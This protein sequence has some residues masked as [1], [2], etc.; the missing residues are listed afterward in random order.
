M[1]TKIGFLSNSENEKILLEFSSSWLKEKGKAIELIEVPF[2]NRMGLGMDADLRG[3]LL[4]PLDSWSFVS[5]WPRVSEEV[6]FLQ[7]A[8]C[9]LRSEGY[10][11]PRLLFPE[12][13]RAFIA[14]QAPD[15]D[16]R[17]TA[18]VV[19]EGAWLRILGRLCLSMG[20]KKLFL[21]SEQ[22]EDL[23]TSVEKVWRRFWGAEI[24]ALPAYQLTL[25]TVSASLIVVSPLRQ[26]SPGL[27]HDIAYFNVML[28]Q[29]LLIDLNLSASDSML[30][31][32]AMQAGLRTLPPT[33]I[34]AFWLRDF[35][36][37][38]GLWDQQ[39]PEQDFQFSLKNHLINLE[40]VDSG[41]VEDR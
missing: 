24:I 29:G 10:L 34:Y 19:G 7:V 33:E 12:S 4:D 32:E 8:D 20:F 38:V 17:Q 2:G 21:V 30:V 39:L 26:A 37:H 27:V 40:S 41:S 35:L 5:E 31:Q 36:T 3:I 11:W 18:Y 9:V 1:S 16:T 22:E 6:A 25:Q 14:H 28:P 15:L 13:I 23:K